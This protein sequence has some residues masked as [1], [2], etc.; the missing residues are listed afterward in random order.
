MTFSSHTHFGK[1][2]LFLLSIFILFFACLY[3]ASVK[4]D[5]FFFNE[6]GTS[7]WKN[8]FGSAVQPALDYPPG[9]L[10]GEAPPF[11]EKV[12]SGLWL[13]IK[14]AICAIS[15]ALPIGIVF[16]G[17]TSKSWWPSHTSPT[18]FKITLHTLRCFAKIIITAGRSLHEIIWALLFITALGTSPFAIIIALAIPYG[19]TL[20]KVYAEILDEQS[21]TAKD[22]LTSQGGNAFTGWLFG[23]LPSALPDILGYTFYR[24]ECAIRSSAILGFVGISTIGLHIQQAF[25]DGN[26]G[27]VWTHLIVLLI[28]III[29]ER[30]CFI[31]RK[32]ITSEKVSIHKAK[33]STL[34]AL[35]AVKPKNTFIALSFIVIIAVT[36]FTWLEGD[37]LF[38]D[39][40]WEKRMVNLERFFSKEITPYPV[41]LSGNWGDAIPWAKQLFVKEGFEASYMTICIGTA[42]M[43]LAFISAIFVL[44]FATKSLN[45]KQPLDIFNGRSKLKA[46]SKSIVAFTLRSSFVLSRAMPE[47]LLAFLLVQLFG[48][49]PWPLILG[50]A[51]HNFGIVG[52]LGSEMI[53]NSSLREA[54]VQLAHGGNS[55]KTYLFSLLPNHFNRF[56]LYFFYRWETCIRDATVLGILGITSLGYSINE[57]L[58]RDHKDEMMFYILL[59]ACIVFIG[60]MLSDFVRSKIR[61]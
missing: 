57:A 54:Q 25:G 20:A 8:F 9:S 21:A 53:D 50:L 38:G 58:A 27:E 40:P 48:P 14:Y 31:L 12:L 16:A 7:I 2:R 37:P 35:K 51:I 6:F 17:L 52:R 34:S 59:G 55:L 24:F 43:T 49:S 44:P 19:C 46:A 28:T 32:R 22:F 5:N 56:L 3:F 29:V 18:L 4:W 26:Y 41:Q 10:T 45:T 60:D 33:D 1:R 42:A 23:I 30:C 36:T 11:L 39:M 61:G 47:F 15:L 13:T